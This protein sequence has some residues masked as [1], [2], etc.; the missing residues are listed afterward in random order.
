MQMVAGRVGLYSVTPDCHPLLG[1]VNGVEGLFLGT[2]GSGHCFKLGPAIGEMIA[3][4]VLDH[5]VNFA[6]ITNFEMSRF[7]RGQT[8]ASTLAATVNEQHP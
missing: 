2:G 6:D 3:G 4:A 7:E 8:F 5:R 1:R